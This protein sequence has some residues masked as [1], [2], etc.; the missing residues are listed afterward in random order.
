MKRSLAVVLLISLVA[1]AAAPG[2][3]AADESSVFDRVTDA[4][5]TFYEALFGAVRGEIAR[6]FGEPADR[7][8]AQAAD[9]L[10]AEYN[11]SSDT[12][13]AWVNARTEAT[14]A[15]NVLE[16]ELDIDDGETTIYLVADVNDSDYENSSIVDSTD[17]EVDERCELEDAAAR[18]AADELETFVDEFAEDDED[19]STAFLSRLER[20]YR[21]L[22]DCSF[23]LET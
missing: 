16:L 9:D 17:R 2:V 20:Q 10:Q 21:G 1:T 12:L 18:N 5:G 3:A 15:E 8:A 6:K 19:V 11:A 13:E 23:P 14:T 22:V 4:V 7:D